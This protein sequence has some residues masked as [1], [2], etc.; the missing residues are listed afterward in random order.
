MR[1]ARRAT[2]ALL[3]LLTLGG[4]GCHRSRPASLSPDDRARLYASVLQELRADTAMRWV[5]IDSLLPTTDIDAD[6]HEKVTTELRISSAVL[7]GFLAAQRTPS[8][9]FRPAMLPG[10]RFMP[11][12]MAQLDSMRRKVREDIASGRAERGANNDLFWRRW[13]GAFPGA[14]G[15]VIL[16][17]ALITADGREAMVHVR[18]VCGPVCAEAELRH[19]RR[20]AGGA[21]R[22]MAKVRLSES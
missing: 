11:L 18:V 3:A 6:L 21:W 7:D 16:S 5:V 9:Q 22:T 20:D 19:L 10:G 4:T 13:S 12:H 2:L 15:Y 8:D 1:R 14:G 17:P